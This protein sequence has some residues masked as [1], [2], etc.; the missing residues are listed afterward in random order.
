MVCRMNGACVPRLYS[1]THTT[2]RIDPHHAVQKH[3]VTRPKYC[4][5]HNYLF[6]S[7]LNPTVANRNKTFS[8]SS[9]TSQVTYLLIKVSTY[10]SSVLDNPVSCEAWWRLLQFSRRADLLKMTAGWKCCKSHLIFI[11][12]EKSSQLKRRHRKH[13]SKHFHFNKTQVFLL[14][15]VLSKHS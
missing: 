1:R 10:I 8:A 13:S 7:K 11:R 5:S 9:P 14:F 3:A 2:E 4:P 6:F 12:R 15:F